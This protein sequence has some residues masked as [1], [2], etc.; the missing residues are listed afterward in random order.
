MTTTI[1][2]IMETEVTTTDVP[3]RARDRKGSG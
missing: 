1:T 2:I 3:L